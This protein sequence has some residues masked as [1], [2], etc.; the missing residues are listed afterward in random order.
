MQT[1]GVTAS[2]ASSTHT[3]ASNADPATF[4]NAVASETLIA[5]QEAAQPYVPIQRTRSTVYQTADVETEC[6]DDCDTSEDSPASDGTTGKT[7]YAAKEGDTLGSIASSHGQSVD[8]ILLANP[9]L[10]PASPLT[11]GQKIEILDEIRLA[12]WREIAATSDPDRLESLIRQEMQYATSNSATP[13]DLLQAVIDDIFK[14]RPTDSAF[15]DAVGEQAAWSSQ[16]W[17]SQGRTHEVMDPLHA[18]AAR[19]DIAGVEKAVLDIMRTVAATTPTVTAIEGQ[20]DVLLRYGPQ[21]ELFKCAVGDAVNDFLVERPAQ[22]AEAIADAFEA[23]GPLAAAALLRGYTQAG[24]VDPLSAALILKASRETISSIIDYLDTDTTLAEGENAATLDSLGRLTIFG[25]LSAAAD[26]ASRSPVASGTIADM[27]SQINAEGYFLVELSIEQGN[28]IVLPLEM[29]KQSDDASTRTLLAYSVLNGIAEFKA[30]LRQSVSEFAENGLLASEP[31]LLWGALLE[32]PE[33]AFEAVLESTQPDGKTLE[34]T[35][36]EDIARIG[37]QGYQLMRMLVALNDYAPHL[38]DFPEL[39]DASELPEQGSD[40]AIE[41]ALGSTPALLEA[42]RATN[43]HALKDGTALDPYAAILDP[44]WFQGGRGSG[45]W[46]TREGWDEGAVSDAPL[47]VGLALGDLGT[48]TL[49]VANKAGGGGWGA[50]STDLL[51]LA[52]TTLEAT[53]AISAL[54]GLQLDLSGMTPEQ[55]SQ[56]PLLQRTLDSVSNYARLLHAV[57]LSHL[58]TFGIFN[59]VAAIREIGGSHT[60]AVAPP[61]TETPGET[62]ARQFAPLLASYVAANPVAWSSA[63]IGNYSVSS[64]AQGDFDFNVVRWGATGLALL[65]NHFG[66]QDDTSRSEPFRANYLEASGVR[67]EVARALAGA[68]IAPAMQALSQHLNLGPGELLG[69]FSQQDAGWVADFASRELSA[70]DGSS[71]ALD[72]LI[73]TAAN[74]GHPLPQHRVEAFA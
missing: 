11:P 63:V 66:D 28:G 3:G 5:L 36:A 27:A 22:A 60:P 55:I 4:Q 42:L 37:T 46:N 34:Q 19:G 61:G 50:G 64:T 40:P 49:G 33:A 52:Q 17:K 62:F 32:E 39:L 53:Q 65:R 13:D 24:N 18:L 43:T 51:Y 23:N 56:L 29:I 68:N 12:H 45:G 70:W 73:G 21:T 26:S 54:L 30:Q 9:E 14:L 71:P 44:G 20:H 7:E 67:P 31:A 15:A 57:Y 59:I 1:D 6:A 69:W 74:T 47:G 10:D 41:L 35:I 8:D 58:E 48:E 25:H 38:Q 16:L 2:A 72:N